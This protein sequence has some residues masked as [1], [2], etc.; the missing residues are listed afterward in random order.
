MLVNLYGFDLTACPL[1]KRKTRAVFNCGR[2]LCSLF[3]VPPKLGGVLGA[4]YAFKLPLGGKGIAEV[5]SARREIVWSKCVTY[6]RVP[7]LLAQLLHILLCPLAA[8][9]W[10]SERTFHL[11]ISPRDI[12]CYDISVLFS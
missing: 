12:M 8:D 2:P 10:R 6:W 7:L 3:T 11:L 9:E 4:L 5:L 1:I